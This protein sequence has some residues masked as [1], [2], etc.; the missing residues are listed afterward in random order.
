MDNYNRSRKNYQEVVGLLPAAGKAT[1]LAR[2]PC[3]KE[4]YP[5]G[6]QNLAN[7]RGLQSKPV[8]IYLLEKMRLAGISKAYIIL[9]QGK[10]D[11]PG[12]LRDG[13]MFGLHLAYVMMN[14]PLGVPYTLDQA[15]PFLNNSAVA[16]GFPD[17]IFKPDDAFVQLL[18]RQARSNAD[19]V[20]A[21]FPAH[22]SHKADM[23]DVD[24]DGRIIGIQ[25]KPAQ[26]HLLFAWVIAVW[27]PVFTQ[28][29]HEY[30]TRIQDKSR[31][32][33][34]DNNLPESRELFVGDV[35]QAAIDD[36]LYV[37]GIIFQD[38]TYLDIGTQDSLF[39]AVRDSVLQ[40]R[41]EQE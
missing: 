23:V 1:R 33:N 11:I 40:G 19:I 18:A 25:I 20:L 4:L 13:S 16:L 27:T 26:T 14:L 17:I 8:C 9:R 37:E 6:F 7:G 34:T 12:Y 31:Q 32:N 3:S 5:I 30:L 41:P 2:L 28:F 36:N 21:L 22:Q 39:K 35:I 10:W 29:M 38:G 24:A 15:Y